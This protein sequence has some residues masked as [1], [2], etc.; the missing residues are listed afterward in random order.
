MLR[1]HL[2]LISSIKQMYTVT[3]LRFITAVLFSKAGKDTYQAQ[4]L[5]NRSH[6][7]VMHDFSFRFQILAYWTHLGTHVILTH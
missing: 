5:P 3:C 2:L 1:L 7:G 4:K 6:L